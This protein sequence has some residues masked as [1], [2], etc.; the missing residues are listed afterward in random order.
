MSGNAGP[1]RGTQNAMRPQKLNFA[2]HYLWPMVVIAM[3]VR[4]AVHGVETVR[5]QPGRSL[6]RERLR[7]MITDGDVEYAACLATLLERD[8]FDV[9]VAHDGPETLALVASFRPHAALLDIALPQKSG[10][11]TGA[12]IRATSWGRH[13][14]LVATSHRVSDADKCA[15]LAAGFDCQL[16]RP[17][18]YEVLTEFLRSAASQVRRDTR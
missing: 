2:P 14:V 1:R 9:Q 12:A 17:I 11:E 5:Q 6:R 10:F 4:M 3:G 18:H 7:A 13:M 15:A 8:G 16:T